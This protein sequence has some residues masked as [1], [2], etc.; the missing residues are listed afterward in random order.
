MIKR[1][2]VILTF[3][4][5]GS[6][7]AGPAVL[8]VESSEAG[9]EDLPDPGI[10]PGSPLYFLKRAWEGLKLRLTRAPE[11]RAVYIAHLL[12]VRLAECSALAER[13]RERLLARTLEDYRALADRAEAEMEQAAGRG[14]DLTEALVAV[15]RATRKGGE[16][17]TRVMGE[18][19]E[20]AR[21]AVRLALQAAN[22]GRETCLR[23]MERVH[24]GA[25]PGSREVIAELLQ[26]IRETL[27][28]GWQLPPGL[29]PGGGPD[30]DDDD[31]AESGQ[32]PGQGQGGQD[33]GQSQAPAQA[34]TPGQG[35]TPGQGQ[36]SS[37]SA[38]Q[39]QTPGQ[40]QNP[41]QGGGG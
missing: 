12:E 37:Q 24:Q 21:T 29:G 1:L 23:M 39:G 15:E 2:A 6:F 18:V 19:P 35:E 27:P 38:G 7:L 26:S 22:F 13:G 25:V 8:A 40:G 14:A 34:Q 4:M 20:Q 5:I 10:L 28:A 11:D 9:D 41:G 33:L 17:L 30:G 31:E 16:V 36:S 32:A 3:M